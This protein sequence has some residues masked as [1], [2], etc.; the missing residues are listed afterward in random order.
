MEIREWYRKH[1]KL[2]ITANPIEKICFLN[3]QVLVDTT[4]YLVRDI[5]YFPNKTYSFIF[6]DLGTG[7]ILYNDIREGKSYLFS[8]I[9]YL[10]NIEPKYVN[11]KRLKSIYEDYVL[12]P[13]HSFIWYC[14]FTLGRESVSKINLVINPML[15]STI[16][17]KL[18]EVLNKY[19]Q[20]KFYTSTKP[21][22]IINKIYDLLR[23]VKLDKHLLLLRK[24]P[25]SF[26][27]YS[28]NSGAFITYK[29]FIDNVGLSKILIKNSTY[30]QMCIT[31]GALSN[32][33]RNYSYDNSS[34]YIKE[35]R[36]DL[37]I[38]NESLIDLGDISNRLEVIS[39]RQ[40]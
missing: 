39:N 22:P 4:S 20:V 33:L 14:E 24:S 13:K 18:N 32:I 5:I 34:S 7:N 31:E 3:E 29:P 30:N 21:I 38:I 15:Y 23:I 19:K 36:S 8:N 37:G 17:N 6:I 26:T 9:F 27:S 25:T 11:V 10:L 35:G 12:I 40:N 16:N 28:N 2:E 1:Y